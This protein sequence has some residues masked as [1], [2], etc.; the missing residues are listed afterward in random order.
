MSTTVPFRRGRALPCRAQLGAQRQPSGKLKPQTT[1]VEGGP[2]EK[3]SEG[4][5]ASGRTTASGSASGT[6]SVSTV[7]VT[8]G[9]ETVFSARNWQTTQSS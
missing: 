6:V 3:G 9:T 4:A 8:T 5:G 7:S 1:A 2:R